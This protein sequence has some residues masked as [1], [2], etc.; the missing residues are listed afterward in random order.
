MPIASR[1]IDPTADR[2]RLPSWVAS[3]VKIGRR[4]LAGCPKAFDGSAS[5]RQAIGDRGDGQK[6]GGGVVHHFEH[7]S[8]SRDWG[9]E[10]VERCPEPLRWNGAP[11]RGVDPSIESLARINPPLCN[12]ASIREGVFVQRG[13][14]DSAQTPRGNRDRKPRFVQRRD[15]PSRVPN[16]PDATWPL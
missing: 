11:T 7:G 12:V 2:F 15:V 13:L 9:A 14:L 5:A 1:L 8:P 6:R 16:R 4:K 10:R 3:Q